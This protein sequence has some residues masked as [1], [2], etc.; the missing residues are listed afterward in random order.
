MKEIFI[1]EKIGK[2][3]FAEN[4]DIGQEIRLNEIMPTLL[5]NEEVILNFSNVDRASQSF[6]HSLISDPI[7][8]LGVEKALKLIAFKACND[9]LKGIIG[10]VLDYMQDAIN[11]GKE[12]KE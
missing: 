5:K 3:D 6:I 8:K 1:F 12:T 4:K 11:R 7:R 2:K 10:I 9:N